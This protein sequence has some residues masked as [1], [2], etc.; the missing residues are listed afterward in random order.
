MANSSSEAGNLP[1]ELLYQKQSHLRETFRVVSK[2]LRQTKIH[3]Y[4]NPRYTLMSHKVSG[5]GKLIGIKKMKPVLVTGLHR[6]FQ[7]RKSEVT[8]PK[9][10]EWQSTSEPKSL[11]CK[12][13]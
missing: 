5:S 10:K 13:E 11:R 7:R 1:D 12:R 4:I 9:Q 6:T 3:R 2:G 8:C